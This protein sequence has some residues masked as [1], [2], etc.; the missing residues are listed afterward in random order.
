VGSSAITPKYVANTVHKGETVLNFGAGKPDKVTGK[1]GHSEMIRASGAIVDEYDFGSNSTGSL[2]KK[3]DTVFASN[4]LNTQSS[5]AM[6]ESTL[7]QIKGSVK[8]GGR[9]VF[10][11]PVSPRYL[12]MRAV[13]VE[14]VIK[15]VFGVSQPP[16][17]VGGT[18]SSPLW[19]LTL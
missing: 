12:H 6:L 1:Y 10:N 4:V 11:Y 16:Q 18:H 8:R 5:R 2:G 19:E 15:G 9:T 13:E 7:D 17:R 3:Y 14:A